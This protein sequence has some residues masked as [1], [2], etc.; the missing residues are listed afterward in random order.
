VSTRNDDTQST[1][2]D[3][4][5]VASAEE[6]A[7]IEV[8]RA[9][10]SRSTGDETT[11]TVVDA[12]SD[13]R[14]AESRST[15]DETTTTVVDAASPSVEAWIAPLREERDRLKDQLLRLAADYDNF[16]KRS[17][18]DIEEAERRAREETVRELLPV[19]DNLERAIAAGNQAPDLKSIIE[20]LNMVLKLFED[21]ARRLGIERLPSVG[22]RFDPAIHDAIQQKE[23]DEYPPGT[24]IAEITAG[25]RLGE[26]LIRPAS[27]VVAR[28]PTSSA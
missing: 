3:G 11:T 23:T 13:E 28:K 27:V 16:R 10:E 21:H 7:R 18:K 26:R 19:F 14:P 5:P 12:T 22:E 15:G 24:V 25:Y 2:V 9:E 20:G 8:E 6:S 1:S 4:S 17:R